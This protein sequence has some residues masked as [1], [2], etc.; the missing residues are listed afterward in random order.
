ML[1]PWTTDIVLQQTRFTHLDRNDDYGTRELMKFTFGMN[2]ESTLFYIVMYRCCYSSGNF[3]RQMTGNW[4]WDLHRIMTVGLSNLGRKPYQ[5]FLKKG[6][7]I[8]DFLTETGMDVFRRLVNHFPD[9]NC[10]TLIT[11]ANV[12]ADD[13]K[14]THEKRHPFLGTEIAKDISAI[15]PHLVNPDSWCLFNS[16]AIVALRALPRGCRTE[17]IKDL[18]ELTGF[19][20]SVLEHSLCEWGKYL[21]RSEYFRKNRQFPHSW[22]YKP[23]V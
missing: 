3:F 1:F 15:Y 5:V 19:Y 6:Q 9:F 12:I 16:G 13:I 8:E 21:E 4:R 17:N 22:R 11:A 10:E 2:E 14:I 7:S 18:I 23:R 20:P